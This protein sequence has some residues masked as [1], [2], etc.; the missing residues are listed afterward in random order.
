MSVPLEGTGNSCLHDLMKTGCV[1]KFESLRLRDFS[2]SDDN[3]SYFVMCDNSL[4]EF[5][6]SCIIECLQFINMDLGIVSLYFL[7]CC[8]NA[9][10]HT[11][12]LRFYSFFGIQHH[13]MIIIAPKTNWLNVRWTILECKKCRLYGTA[14][15]RMICL[16]FDYSRH[17]LRLEGS[18]GNNTKVICRRDCALGNVPAPGNTSRGYW[19]CNYGPNVMNPDHIV[20]KEL[21]I[22]RR[23]DKIRSKSRANRL[24]AS[25][26]M[27]RIST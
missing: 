23:Y 18:Y 25:I 27:S 24:L 12:A 7:Q 20:I 19:Q 17:W 22:K 13:L 14:S 6:Y 11:V 26:G 4:E 3:T 1:W 5:R 9:N 21:C 16:S 8:I 15:V 10:E 2:S